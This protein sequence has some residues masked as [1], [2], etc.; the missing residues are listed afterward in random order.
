MCW[1]PVACRVHL[2]HSRLGESRQG[3]DRWVMAVRGH[4]DLIRVLQFGPELIVG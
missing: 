2:R 3:G 4:V 1:K